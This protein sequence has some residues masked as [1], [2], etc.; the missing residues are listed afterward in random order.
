[1]QDLVEFR[2]ATLGVGSD[3]T[4]DTWTLQTVGGDLLS[5]GVH[6]CVWTLLLIIIETGVAKKLN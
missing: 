2:E 1:M 3:L 4:N 5:L 6:F